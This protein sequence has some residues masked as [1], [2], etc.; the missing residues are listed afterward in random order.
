MQGNVQKP[1]LPLWGGPGSFCQPEAACLVCPPQLELPWLWGS[2]PG[3]E[4]VCSQACVLQGA[5]G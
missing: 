1:S 2:R 3:W 5:L 4:V